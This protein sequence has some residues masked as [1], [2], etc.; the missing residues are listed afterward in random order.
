MSTAFQVAFCP[1]WGLYPGYG[2]FCALAGVEEVG[3]F[4][5]L[6]EGDAAFLPQPSAVLAS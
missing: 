5:T 6:R 1:L 2:E 3:G 4:L